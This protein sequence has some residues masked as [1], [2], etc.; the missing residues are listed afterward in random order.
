MEYLDIEGATIRMLRAWDDKIW[1]AEH[2]KPYTDMLN[3]RMISSKP[4]LGSEPVQGGSSRQEQNLC[5]LIDKL[6][7]AS[8]RYE[9]AVKFLQEMDSAWQQLTADEQYMI[10]ERW[11]NHGTNNGI[12]HI[13]EKFYVGKTEAYDRS[14]AALRRLAVLIYG[15]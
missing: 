10:T 5:D 7:I 12:D 6:D 11:I 15:M 3:D 8:V 14:K 1:I 13:M 2:S 4:S 9:H